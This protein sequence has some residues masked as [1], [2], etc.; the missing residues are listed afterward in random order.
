MTTSGCICFQADFTHVVV[1]DDG[2]REKRKREIAGK[3]GKEMVDRR[4]ECVFFRFYSG[5]SNDIAFA[6]RPLLSRQY[7]PV[8]WYICTA[9]SQTRDK[10]NVQPQAIPAFN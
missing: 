7:F 5:F 8:A 10:L 9:I 1:L 4:E 2:K 6:Q 3:L